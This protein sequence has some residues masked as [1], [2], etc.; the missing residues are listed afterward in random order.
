MISRVLKEENCQ[1]GILCP[2]ELL[3]KKAKKTFSDTD[4]KNPSLADLPVFSLKEND[5]LVI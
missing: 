3:Q 1:P 5:M 2:A 4:Q